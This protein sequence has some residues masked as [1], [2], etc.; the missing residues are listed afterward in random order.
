MSNIFPTNYDPK[1]T[2]DGTD[3]VWSSDAVTNFNLTISSIALYTLTNA[4]TDDLDEWSV[5]KYYTEARVDANST[6]VSKAN[7]SNVIEKDST[8][9]YTPTLD[10]HPVNKGYVDNAWTNING[11][12]EK[13]N[14]VDNDEFVIYDSVWLVN[15]KIWLDN[16]KQSMQDL[17]VFPWTTTT[18][19]NSPANS[20]TPSTSYT[21]L[22]TY[23]ATKT[24]IYRVSYSWSS[25]SGSS[26]FRVNVNWLIYLPLFVNSDDSWSIEWTINAIEWDEIKFQWK[27]NSWSTGSWLSDALIRWT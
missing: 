26:D 6:V 18:Y 3:V 13:T 25:F 12:T 15:K 27:F 21:D 5:N 10:T 14:L 1:T 2:P 17:F 24:G 7:K 23:T 11:L 8:T 9:P 16:L 20:D 19:F 4:T 22:K